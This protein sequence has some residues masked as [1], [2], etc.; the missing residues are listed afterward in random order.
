MIKIIQ[1]LRRHKRAIIQ[2]LKFTCVG[3]SNSLVYLG[4][5]Y[6][7]TFTG[8]AT[9]MVAQALAWVI[10]V[11]NSFIWNRKFV[12]AGQGK[13]WWQVLVRVYA[14]YGFGLLVSSGLTFLQVHIWGM[15]NA[16]VPI[17]NLP[18]MGLVNF[19]VIKYFAFGGK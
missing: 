6:L 13:A 17:I 3:T 10:S 12:F 2:F 14:G 9:E 18:A 1:F 7:I 15:P 4:V 19:F 11:F 16:I 8:T 5:Y